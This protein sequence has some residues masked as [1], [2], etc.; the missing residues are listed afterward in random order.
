VAVVAK[1]FNN[2]GRL[3][4][5]TLDGTSGL[6]TILFGHGDG[7]FAAQKEL[8]LPADDPQ[9]AGLFAGRPVQQVFG[10][11]IRDGYTDT[12]FLL[13]TGADGPTSFQNR[14][15]LERGIPADIQGAI[16]TP[17][18]PI[19]LRALLT[20]ES[21]LHANAVTPSPVRATP[22]FADFN[23]VPDVV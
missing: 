14:V 13:P 19:P 6:V 18:D 8:H 4:L 1:D 7:T 12:A 16:D 20:Q 3:D 5:A 9:V 17:L 23:G 10:D 2:D 21:Q 15:F 22:L 11:F